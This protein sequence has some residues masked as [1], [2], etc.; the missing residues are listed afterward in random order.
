MTKFHVVVLTKIYT[1]HRSIAMHF[2]FQLSILVVLPAQEMMNHMLV[3]NNDYGT[4][5]FTWDSSV[6]TMIH[7]FV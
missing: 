2:S 6:F 7:H 3:C 1:F 5:K 4:N